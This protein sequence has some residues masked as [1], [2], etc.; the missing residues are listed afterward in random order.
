MPVMIISPLDFIV[1]CSQI[2]AVTLVCNIITNKNDVLN[3]KNLD[4]T[5]NELV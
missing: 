2:S 3:Y 5:C 4:S 1:A